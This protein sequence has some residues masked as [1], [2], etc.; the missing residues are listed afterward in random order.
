M[1]QQLQFPVINKQSDPDMLINIIDDLISDNVFITKKIEQLKSDND[2]LTKKIELL[3]NINNVSDKIIEQWK[4][5]YKKLYK[6]VL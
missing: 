1:N 5:G 6:N 4:F 3:E 2:F